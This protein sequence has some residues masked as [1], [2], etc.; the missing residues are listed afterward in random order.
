MNENLR[1]LVHVESAAGLGH[2]AGISK[3]VA[4]LTENHG[5]DVTVVSG[6]F[7]DP[8]HILSNS[9]DFSVAFFLY[10]KRGA[11]LLLEQRR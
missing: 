4:A 6:T 2:H 1:A 7:V 11:I 5:F 9:F 8:P 10:Q 3:V